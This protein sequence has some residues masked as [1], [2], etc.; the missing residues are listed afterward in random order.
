MGASSSGNAGSVMLPIF[1]NNDR[2]I[3]RR[4][5]RLYY[6]ATEAPV[7]TVTMNIFVYTDFTPELQHYVKNELPGHTVYFNSELSIDA[8]ENAFRTAEVILGN[9]PAAWF[10]PPP[11]QLVFWQIDSA[12]FDRYSQLNIPV[13]VANMGDYF[14]QPCAETM[15]AG[16]LAFYRGIHRL[17][18]LQTIKKWEGKLIQTPMRLLSDQRVIIL[19]AGAI[20]LY[21]ED[22]LSGFGCSV[23]LV[24]R[25]STAATIH[26][27][28]QFLQALPQ[29]SL[30]INTLPGSAGQYMDA[31]CIAAM[32]KGSV[33]A[34]VGRGETTDEA[35]LIAALQSGR[36]AGAVLDVTEKEPLPEDNVLWEMENVILTQ[37]TG[38]RKKDE[39]KG[40]ADL[41]VG[42]LELFIA[43][44][45]VHNIILLGRGY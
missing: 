31:A 18:R 4:K 37:H 34:S 44:K 20:G 9:P 23:R 19:G 11:P 27:K 10:N 22:M 13:P 36:L 14:A 24:A 30:V 43:G 1:T 12:G 2:L 17:A 3:I 8:A 28:E 25:T 45:P 5:I 29:S 15:V 16:V 42:N 21:I 26:T 33:Y 6:P 7:N 35:A 32:P 41:F 39:Y 40:I 38:G